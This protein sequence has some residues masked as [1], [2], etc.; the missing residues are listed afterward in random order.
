MSEG[1]A[2]GDRPSVEDLA[3]P[4]ALWLGEHL[5]GTG[6]VSLGPFEK[7]G[8]GLSG[9]TVLIDAVRQG[10]GETVHEL[11]V[12]FPATGGTGLFPDGDLARELDFQ[13]LLDRTGLPVAPVV[14]YDET[15]RIL[16]R[17]FV[18]T[19]KVPGRVV[20]SSDPYLSR[21][22]LH[23]ASEQHQ[24][25]LLTGFFDTLAQMHRIE[26]TSV[27]GNGLSDAVRRWATYL[28][29]ADDGSA[30]DELHDAADWCT[31]NLPP[32]PVP[33]SAL[34][35]DPQLANAVFAD[36]GSIAALLDFELCHVG[37]AELDVGWFLCLH[38]MTVAR[39]GEDLPGF[40]DRS[41]LL[42]RYEERLGRGLE[43]L[44]WYEI[45]GAVC[46]ASILVRVSV[47]LGAGGADFSRL[48]RTNPA[49]DYLRVR[50]R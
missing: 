34:W 42:A 2:A 5:P 26:S 9:G 31:R 39:C 38:D 11:V 48:A 35:G 49:L 1:P 25:R 45:F 19:K 33:Q 36:D 17:P 46:T 41:R 10:A 44:G 32:E 30:P 14:G 37:P 22:W 4:L 7:P 12:R 47:L 20:A 16:G 23:D 27:S 18:V 3:E 6:P 29:W 24:R 40:S 50:L 28:E 21:G 15:A 13:A 43:H 8:S